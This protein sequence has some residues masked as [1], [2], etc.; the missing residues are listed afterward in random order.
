MDLQT[1]INTVVQNGFLTVFASTVLFFMVKIGNV[2]IDK[3]QN[4]NHILQD[5]LILKL[6][7]SMVWFQSRLTLKQIEAILIEN[8]IQKR[9]DEISRQIKNAI[10]RSMVYNIEYF[11]LLK[12][13]I[14]RIWTFYGKIFEEDKFFQEV[15]DVVLRP[16]ENDVHTTEINIK[17]KDISEIMFHYQDLANSKLEEELYRVSNK[18]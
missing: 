14:E 11:N 9:K 2:Y 12:T 3:I 7:R 5:D 18:K 17:I 16:Y 15:I 4:N 13:N 6:V 1:I 10:E 8:N